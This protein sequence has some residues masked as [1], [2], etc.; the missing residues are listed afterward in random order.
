M[1][2]EWDPKKA[3]ANLRKHGVQ[4]A[5][6][7]PVFEDEL[8]VTVAEETDHEQRWVT[9]GQDSLGGI[10]V[11]VYTRRGERIRINS[12]RRATAN[13]RRRYEEGA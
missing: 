8:A 4:F 3:A 2:F 12:A 5:D 6:A 10:P 11:V 1:S 13:E 9:L 7:V